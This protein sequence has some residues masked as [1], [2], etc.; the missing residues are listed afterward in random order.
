MAKSI[1][2]KTRDI[3]LVKCIKDETERLLTNDKDIKK[4]WQEYFNKLF[5]EDSGSSSIELDISSNDLNRHFVSRIQES[6]VKDAFK[7]MKGDKAMGLDG[8]PI[9]VWRSLGDVAI[10]WLTKLFNLI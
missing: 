7:R 1:E 4:R 8:I 9:E 2:R 6:E 5:N 3:I 10:V